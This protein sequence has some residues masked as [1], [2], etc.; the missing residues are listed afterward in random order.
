MTPN[1]WQDFFDHYAPRYMDEPFVKATLAEV[2]F[3][4]E[5][6]QLVP[7]M[8]V[9]DVGCGTGRHAVELAKR[10]LHMTGVDISSGM[11]THAQLAAEKAGVQ[12]EWVHSPA[13]A[14]QTTQP[15]D[16]VYSVCEGALS[17][18]GADDSFDRDTRVFARMFAALKPGGRALI[19]VLNGMRYL[20]LYSADD[21]RSG[22]FDPLTMTE[23]GTMAVETPDGTRSIPTRERGYIPTE[24]RLMLQQAGFVVDVISGGT[25][26]NWRLTPPDMDEM[27]LMAL[28]H[29]PQG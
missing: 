6:L 14:Y 4:I 18:L 15:F 28:L 25:A 22:R 5:H 12:V 7:G 16:A 20:R 26:G 10:G 11:L 17:L 21:I 29:R 23:H 2:D 24:L 27:E 13:D 8:R 9:L 1:H 19:T 3:M